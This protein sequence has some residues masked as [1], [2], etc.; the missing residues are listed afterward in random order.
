MT[1]MVALPLAVFD[2]YCLRANSVQGQCHTGGK[3]DPANADVI[4][5]PTRPFQPYGKAEPVGSDFPDKE[6]SPKFG[7]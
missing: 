3:D 7:D 2:H 1:L 5:P 6:S 4:Y